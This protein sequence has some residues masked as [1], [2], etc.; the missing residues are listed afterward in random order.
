MLLLSPLKLCIDKQTTIQP[1]R[2]SLFEPQQN[3]LSNPQAYLETC[4]TSKMGCFVEVF[5]G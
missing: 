2:V 4:Q 1:S 3:N 5:N